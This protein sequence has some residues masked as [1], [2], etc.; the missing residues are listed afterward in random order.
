MTTTTLQYSSNPHKYEYIL[1]KLHSPLQT[2]SHL[3]VFN[4]KTL[5]DK[6]TALNPNK[7]CIYHD[8]CRLFVHRDAVSTFYL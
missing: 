6:K 7:S 8:V 3:P 5:N 4:P 1:R 2:Y